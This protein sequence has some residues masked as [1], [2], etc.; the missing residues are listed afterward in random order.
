MGKADMTKADNSP[1]TASADHN[2]GRSS[3]ASSPE[4]HGAAGG[5]ELERALEVGVDAEEAVAI[6]SRLREGLE[7]RA[8][9]AKVSGELGR[10]RGAEHAF[11]VCEV[12]ELHEWARLR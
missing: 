10:G 4:R 9:L 3:F 11:V 7:S 5:R 12:D 2:P 6:L 1:P 8:P